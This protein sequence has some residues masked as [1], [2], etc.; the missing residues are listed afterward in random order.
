MNSADWSEELID[1]ERRLTVRA[2]TEPHPALRPRVLAA[3]KSGI[4]SAER[5]SF[6][7]FVTGL[8]AVLLLGANLTMSSAHLVGITVIDDAEGVKT[9]AERLHTLVPEIS[10]ES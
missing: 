9:A 7:N 3:L 8:A 4:R 5:E 1:L 10:V 6:W 2:R